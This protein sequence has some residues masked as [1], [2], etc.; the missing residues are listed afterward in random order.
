RGTPHPLPLETI[1]GVTVGPIEN[2]LQPGRGYGTPYS[3][4]LLNHLARMGVNWIS[5]TPFGRIWSLSSTEIYMDFESP[6]EENRKAIRR[7]IEQAHARGMKVL[8]VPHL[9]VWNEQGWRGEIHFGSQAEWEEYL[10]SYRA[11]LLLWAHDAASAHADALSIGVECTSWSWRFREFWVNLIEEVRSVFP[12]LL[13]YSANWDEVWDAGF[14]D[15][16][17]VIGVNAFYPL[18]HHPNASFEEYLGN[19]EKVA[20][21]LELLSKVWSKP[22]LFVEVGYTSRL[23]AGVEPWL[24]PDGMTG[25]R[26]SEEEQARALE[27]ILWALGKRKWFIGFFV[28]R[29]YANLDDLSQEP[30]WGFSPHAKLAEKVLMQLFSSPFEWDLKDGW[31]GWVERRGDGVQLGQIMALWGSTAAYPTNSTR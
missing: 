8:L 1:K 21:E 20:S 31:F 15:H 9:W 17:D 12:G 2:S 26:E 18:A 22:L 23:N 28:W 14:W 24:W 29:Y 4:A 5:V 7:F 25:V 6:Y 16:L 3:E 11:F 27:A 10:Q 30:P 13:T 19:A